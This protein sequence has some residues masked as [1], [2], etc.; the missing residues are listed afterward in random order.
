[1]SQLTTFLAKTVIAVVMTFLGVRYLSSM[2]HG[3]IISASGVLSTVSGILFGFVLAAITIFTS[4]DSSKG[5]LGALKKNNVL[6]GIICKLLAT[7][8]TL[9]ASCL[10]PLMA[11]FVQGIV[12]DVQVD[13][14][15]TL[16]GM[17]Y[18]IISILTFFLCW[19][20]LGMI[21]PHL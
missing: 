1:M 10:F 7:G 2:D 14:L 13:F 5:L 19:K 8:V 3:N 20:E 6:K 11:M 9:I 18:L 16:L 4:A 15:L 21:I 12:F 17:S